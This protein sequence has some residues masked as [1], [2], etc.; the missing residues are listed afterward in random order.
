MNDLL[1]SDIINTAPKFS[2]FDELL[3]IPPH[4]TELQ[5]HDFFKITK[6]IDDIGL[7]LKELQ[8]V[9]NQIKISNIEDRVKIDWYYEGREQL[10]ELNKNLLDIDSIISRL[11]MVL[12][13]PVNSKNLQYNHLLSKCEEVTDL[14]LDVKKL[15]II[16]KKKTD[17]SINYMELND[18]T[19]TTLNN[20][21]TDCIRMFSKLQDATLSS[22]QQTINTF[23]LQEIVHKMQINK[24]SMR[25]MKSI[26]LP[27][28]NDQDESIYHEYSSLESKLEPLK[29]SINFLP[30]R[31][32][33]FLNLCGDSFP[34]AIF[35][36]NEKFGKLIDNWDSLIMGLEKF[37]VHTIDPKWDK[38]FSFLISEIEKIIDSL[39]N[40]FQTKAN[41]KIN[42]RIGENYKLCSNTITLV[43]KSITERLITNTETVNSYNDNLLVKWRDLNQC[44]VLN[45]N[46][47]DISNYTNNEFSGL[48]TLRTTRNLSSPSRSATVTSPF[49]NSGNDELSS[50]LGI[51][52]GIDIE[53][54]HIP[55]SIKNVEKVRNFESDLGKSAKPSLLHEF[56]LNR[57]VKSAGAALM[58]FDDEETLVPKTNKDEQEIATLIDAVGKVKLT[59]PPKQFKSRIPTIVPNYIKLGYSIIPMPNVT[60]SKIPRISPTHKAFQ[61]PTKSV[62]SV[63][64][65]YSMSLNSPIKFEKLRGKKKRHNSTNNGD[66]ISPMKLKSPSLNLTSTPNLAFPLSPGYASSISTSSPRNLSPKN[67]PPRNLSP[68]NL[69]PRALSMEKYSPPGQI[70]PTRHSSSA[71]YR[72]TSPERPGSSL[73]SRFDNE[74]LLQPLKH[75]KPAWK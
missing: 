67:F 74:N 58:I 62:K 22:P 43:R 38:I 32:E 45:Q 7:Y 39:L 65:D 11:L 64:S 54:L 41:R 56:K 57:R 30:L 44:L 53:N 15:V 2:F 37:K 26:I 18:S 3:L 55:F 59:E 50:G 12:E 66:N 6:V 31:I 72:S 1:L 71:S 10:Y 73:G 49:R 34:D 61:S 63:N 69:S 27:T 21:I 70:S 17:I 40:E 13:L 46:Y 14:S 24:E 4:G 8:S 51:D 19:I 29:V 25:S 20:E 60:Q 75:I 48:K 5:P 33:E 28:F 36:I 68:R 52:L 42:K 16:M 35:V 23:N 9:L 47:D